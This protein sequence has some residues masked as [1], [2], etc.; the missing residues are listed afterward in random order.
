MNAAAVDN[1]SDSDANK[2]SSGNI[3]LTYSRHPFLQQI[4]ENDEFC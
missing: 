2:V 3:A 1:K 4:L